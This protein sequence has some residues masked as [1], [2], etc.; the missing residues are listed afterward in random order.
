[1]FNLFYALL[2]I[3]AFFIFLAVLMIAAAQRE[4]SA[5]VKRIR[6]LVVDPDAEE[7]IHMR[8]TEKAV[9]RISLIASAIRTRMG[10]ETNETVQERFIAAGIRL[11]KV[12]DV[13]Y[14]V[15]ILTPVVIALAGWAI[16]RMLIVGIAG[17]II[18]YIAPSFVLDSLV[19]RYTKRIR[20]A[21]PD[22]VDL[23]VVCVDAGFGI[24]QALL[25]TAREMSIAYPE[26][27]YELIETNRQRQAGLTRE[28]AWENLV[29]RTKVDD[30]EALVSILNQSEQLGTPLASGLRNLSDSL[31]THR[32]LVAQETA[33][34]AS[35]L[36]LIP[37]VLFIFP[38]V[39]IVIMGPAVL[40][41]MNTLSNGVIPK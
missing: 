40:T 26:V 38:T 18:G 27:C 8:T 19:K 28:Q 22:V 41:L 32:R 10:A 12:S 39:F 36:L 15:R 1:M 14:V 34:R 4:R 7:D 5:V 25:R 3:T 30:I 21:M 17:A 31:R 37:L 9:R 2:A 24:E 6:T 13:Y 23:L 16:S 29:S 11:P 20:R 35:V 33:A